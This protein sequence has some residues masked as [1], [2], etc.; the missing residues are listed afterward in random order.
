VRNGASA[1]R[2]ATVDD[3]YD[4]GHEALTAIAC[5]ETD[6]P[7]D[8]RVWPFAARIA[9]RVTPCFGSPWAFISQPCATWP[10]FDRDRY[11]G[12]FDR[13]TRARLLVVNARYDAFWSLA[14]ARKVAD[15]MNA[16]LLTVEGPGHSLEGTDS[17]CADGAVERYL[18]AG[19]LPAEGVVCAQD[20][21]P[22]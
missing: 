16:R 15:S 22:F 21:A 9:D 1:A 5:G 2:L 13:R 7:R 3:E 12:P 10:G 11:A 4:N 17:A 18:I 19:E 20:S 6:N 14:R 8:A